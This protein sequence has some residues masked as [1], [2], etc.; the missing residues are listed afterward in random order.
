MDFEWRVGL[1]RTRNICDEPASTGLAPPPLKTDPNYVLLLEYL[2]L[3][4]PRYCDSDLIIQT[5]IQCRRQE[6]HEER[7]KMVSP[8]AGFIPVFLCSAGRR[9]AFP[10]DR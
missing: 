6:T 9:G 10:A 7:P 8:V 1:Q 5:G 4:A 3:P 2:S